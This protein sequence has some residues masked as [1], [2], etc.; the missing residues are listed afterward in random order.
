MVILGGYLAVFVA[1]LLVFNADLSSGALVVV[2]ALA[3][4]LG[5]AGGVAAILQRRQGTLADLGFEVVNKDGLF[6]LFGAALQFGMAIAFSPLARAV[7]S[8]GTT[9]D[10]ADSIAS[11]RGVPME[12]A[13]IILVGLVAPIMEE[14]AFRGVLLSA[15][16]R[17]MRPVWAAL[18][19]AIVFSLFHT[20]GIQQDNWLAGLITLSQLF[21]VGVILAAITM[22]SDR[23]GP[24]IFTH[25]G[26]NL[27]TLFILLSN[28]P[29]NGV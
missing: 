23:L 29:L 22:R 10:V 12:V 24:S 25:A 5:Q 3:M 21:I 17:R 4:A 16:R 20:L 8:D 28:I 6:L 19:T 11:A 7:Q 27:V 1:G 9:Q 13:I 14:L 18:V 15:V 26:F 2:S